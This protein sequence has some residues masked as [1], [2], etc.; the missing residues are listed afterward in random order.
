MNL[1]R[2]FMLLATAIATISAILLSLA[3]IG[4]PALVEISRQAEKVNWPAILQSTG[5]LFL[6]LLLVAMFKQKKEGDRRTRL[7]Q[8]R[9]QQT[10]TAPDSRAVFSLLKSFFYNFPINRIHKCSDVVSFL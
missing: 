10:K 6:V 2:Y 9:L 4:M 5:F 3:Y 8:G 7:R 1:R